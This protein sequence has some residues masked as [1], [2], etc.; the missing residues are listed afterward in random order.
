VIGERTFWILRKQYAA[1]STPRERASEAATHLRELLTI[2]CHAESFCLYT[3]PTLL[4]SGV[5]ETHVQVLRSTQS[6]DFFS[7]AKSKVGFDA[8]SSSSHTLSIHPARYSV[9]LAICLA[10]ASSLRAGSHDLLF[11]C[12]KLSEIP[13]GRES[14]S[15]I[16]DQYVK[17]QGFFQIIRKISIIHVFFRSHTTYYLLVR[18]CRRFRSEGSR[19]RRHPISRSSLVDFFK[20][21]AKFRSYA[22]FSGLTRLTICLSE[23]VG[24]SDRNGVG[25]GRFRPE[26]I[27]VMRNSKST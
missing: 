26:R 4:P 3:T 27:S 7:S 10:I 24:D 6:C 8:A 21:Y 13:V 14:E 17:F 18:S 9:S 1:H 2:F 11:A 23:A 12:R 5:H 22:Y 19:N 16:S 15:P 20:F 25:I